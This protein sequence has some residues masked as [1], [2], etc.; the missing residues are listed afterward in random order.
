MWKFKCPG[1]FDFNF[2]LD[3][4]S[5][6]NFSCPPPKTGIFRKPASPLS[7]FNGQNAAGVWTLRI[8]DNTL[9]DGG[10]LTTF[11]LKICS[12]AALN[13]PFIV[14]NNPLTLAPGTNAGIGNNLL[15]TS[16]S[17]N[18]PDQLIYTVMTS[19][20]H[21]ELVHGSTLKPGD[22]F[23]QA[24]IDN[25]NLRYFD[26]GLNQGSD[27]FRFSVTDGAGGLVAGTFIIQPFAV[28]TK[29]PGNVLAFD[30]A[31][32]PA[33]ETIRLFFTENLPDNTNIAIYNAAGQ[34]LRSWVAPAGSN[35]MLLN[36][37]DLPG[38]VYAVAVRHQTAGGVKKV[39]VKK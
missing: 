1:T 11:Q 10:Q 22:Q 33:S 12:S 31:P 13:G 18:T 32:N 30:L 16:D 19:P 21:G 4:A 25:G 28:G 6:S 35:T 39:V 29:E 15:K 27:N 23:T 38:G 17:N 9:G 37:E 24:D 5:S 34:L 8:K 2:G 20:I 3:D 26:Y 14:N 7:A 36:I